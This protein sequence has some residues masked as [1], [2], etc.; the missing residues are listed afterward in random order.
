M[1]SNTVKTTF[2]KKKYQELKKSYDLAKKESK[3]ELVFY[4]EVLLVDY[5]KYLLEYL[6]PLVK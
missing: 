4:G 2:D 5:V 1:A 3:K 6:K